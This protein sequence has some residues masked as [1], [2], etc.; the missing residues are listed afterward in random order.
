M[1]P[2]KVKLPSEFSVKLRMVIMPQSW[3]GEGESLKTPAGGLAQHLE[4]GRG[5]LVVEYVAV[6]DLARDECVHLQASADQAEV[7]A[8]VCSAGDQ[9]W[10]ERHTLLRTTNVRWLA[11][12]LSDFL[13]FLPSSV[14]L[15][16]QFGGTW[17]YRSTGLV[18]RS[19][20]ET[21]ALKC[22]CLERVV[23]VARLKVRLTEEVREVVMLAHRLE[24]VIL[25]LEL[26]WDDVPA[27]ERVA[28]I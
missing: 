5:C 14:L 15:W 7:M 20:G 18:L 26:E 1:L 6:N 8:T 28:V 4:T 2:Q 17:Q 3:I 11:D 16:H 22:C 25:R 19:G 24:L 21:G 13:S 27:H 23:P 10:L 12:S 9:Y